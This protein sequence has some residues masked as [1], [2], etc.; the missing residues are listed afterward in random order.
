MSK[1]TTGSLRRLR[2]IGRYLN[3]HPRLVW[4]YAM[5]SEVGELT[6]RIDADGADVGELARAHHEGPYPEALIASIHGG[7]RKQ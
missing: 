1:P 2:R 5:Q 7:R 6:V 3:M 4:K